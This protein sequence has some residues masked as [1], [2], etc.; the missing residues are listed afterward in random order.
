MTFLPLLMYSQGVKNLFV[1]Y[2]TYSAT[3]VSM[4]FFAA[5]LCRFIEVKQL[6]L[7]I[8]LIFACTML[9]PILS[10]TV[11]GLFFIGI[12]VGIAV[13]LGLPLLTSVISVNTRPVDRG[14]ALGFFTTAI[15]LGMGV[16]SI[17][18]GWVTEYF[19]YNK[20]FFVVFLFIFMNFLFYLFWIRKQKPFYRR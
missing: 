6:I 20:M 14:V 19:G 5:Q 15:D 10:K 2:F 13:G 8:L 18:M 4:R 3:V 1:F 11:L 7:Y 12:G 9:V 17:G 16:G